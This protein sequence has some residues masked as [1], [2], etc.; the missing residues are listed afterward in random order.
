MSIGCINRV[1]QQCVSTRCI[2]E[3][4]Q[5]GVSTGC[6]N[7]V[8]QQGVTIGHMCHLVAGVVVLNPDPFGWRASRI[9]SDTLLWELRRTPY[10]GEG[11]EE[12]LTNGDGIIVR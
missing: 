12:D 10:A 6:I 1:Y 9:N 8:Y 4:C 3:V 11:L 2:N 7:R 5:Q